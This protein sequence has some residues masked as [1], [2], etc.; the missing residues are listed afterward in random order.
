MNYRLLS[1]LLSL[2]LLALAAAFGISLGGG[3][4]EGGFEQERRAIPGFAW[5]IGI[6]LVAALG[7]AI[8][9]R[10]ASKTLFR[11]EAL[12]LIGLGWLLA[13]LLG[14]LPYLFI[15]PNCTLAD[16][17]FESASGLTTTGASVFTGFED[18]SRSLLFW[19]CMSQWIGGLG[20]VVFFVAILS[21]LGASGKI[22]FTN[23]NSGTSGEIDTGRVQSGALR[24]MALYLSLSAAT[25]LALYFA[26]MSI[27]DATCHTFSAIS[28]GGFSTRSLSIEAFASPVIEW[29]LI[30]VMA[31][32]A[33]SFLW[34]LRA[35]DRDW[36][37]VRQ[38]SEV[39][40]FYL[41][42]LAATLFIATGLA[43]HGLTQGIEPTIRTAAFQVVSIISTTGYSSTDFGFWHLPAEAVLLGLMVLGGCSGSTAGGT[44]IIRAVIAFRLIIN[45]IEQAFRA[46]VVRP[47]RANGRIV[48]QQAQ[49]NVATY[50]VLNAA[51]V[52]FGILILATLEP[53]MDLLSTISAILS[54]LFNIGPGFGMVGPAENYGFMS[55]PAKLLCTLLMILGRLE[56]YA[57]LVLF[58]PSLWKRFS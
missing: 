23:E 28:T 2:I 58:A 50:I 44:K 48:N 43:T 10:G 41:V 47:I 7:L 14:A 6:T 54:S 8:A 56:L 29:I 26:G 1:R 34:L 51:L 57:I 21:S 46:H 25:G 52:C 49:T 22:L 42:C 37:E 11:K 31:I 40:V 39:T 12:A 4:L 17:I 5:S 36:A 27:Y 55:A 30:A 38:N 45:N 53:E 15:L 13:S 33:T 18:W 20:V 32:G 35:I 9:G 19:R 3:L 24:L 16:A